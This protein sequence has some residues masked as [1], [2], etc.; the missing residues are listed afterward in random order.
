MRRICRQIS[1]PG[2]A[3]PLGIFGAVIVSQLRFLGVRAAGIY[4]A[5]FGG[6]AA[7]FDSSVSAFTFWVL[8]RPGIAQDATLVRA[9]HYF[10]IA[11]GGVGYAVPIGLLMAGVSVTAGFTRLLPKWIVALGLFLAGAGELSWLTMVTT[12]LAFLVPVTRFPGF[13]W[14]IAAGFA[15]P[16]VLRKTPQSEVVSATA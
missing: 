1:G 16:R 13:L 11:L 15:L 9:L 10:A 12:K 5:L 14:M 3:I 7:A 8:A 6:L 4:I 2:S